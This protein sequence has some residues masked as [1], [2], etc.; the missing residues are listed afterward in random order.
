M[1]NL[2]NA[3]NELKT[4]I[5]GGGQTSTAT[6]ILRQSAIEM[7]DTSPTSRANVDPFSFSSISYPR[8]V[9]NDLQNG[10]YML[11]Y[12]YVQN[13]TKYRYTDP[14]K[15]DV[16]GDTYV[17]TVNKETGDYTVTKQKGVGANLSK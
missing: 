6:P 14:F 7:K 9:T 13:K 15:N 1:G 10:H 17:T 3:L 4:N 12:I 2:V 16:G 8:D 11:F 5:F